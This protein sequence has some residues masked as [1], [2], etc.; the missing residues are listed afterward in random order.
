[1]ESQRPRAQ[2][3]LQS[4]HSAN[5]DKDDSY[6]KDNNN[7]LRHPKPRVPH[8]TDANTEAQSSYN[9]LKKDG[10]GSGSGW[11]RSIVL[12]EDLLSRS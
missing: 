7:V 4:G 2:G 6:I 3:L 8:F 5:Y 9:T 11:I 12:C 1:M 10:S